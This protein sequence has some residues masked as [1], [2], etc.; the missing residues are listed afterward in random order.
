MLF[1]GGYIYY[2]SFVD[3]YTK[4]AWVYLL[5]TKS[6]VSQV[7]KVFKHFVELQFGHKIQALQANYGK[8]FLPLTPFLNSFGLKI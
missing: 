4:S 2:L 7:F 1:F 5:K 6:E 8:A 3:M